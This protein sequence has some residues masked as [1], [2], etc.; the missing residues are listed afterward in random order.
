MYLR[1]RGMFRGKVLL[2]LVE[3]AW[4]VLLKCTGITRVV[5]LKCR[6][7]FCRS[8]WL[9]FWVSNQFPGAAGPETTLVE[10]RDQLVLNSQNAGSTGNL[11]WFNDMF[12]ALRRE[13]RRVIKYKHGDPASQGLR[14][15]DF[16]CGPAPAAGILLGKLWAPHIHQAGWQLWV[17]LFYDV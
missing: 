13:Q 16:D 2:S 15:P 1:G 14:K 7:W 5:L 6:L 11:F 8:R 9:R 3:E 10:T 4:A 17:L 12:L